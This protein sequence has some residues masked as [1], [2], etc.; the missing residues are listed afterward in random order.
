MN[1]ERTKRINGLVFAI[2]A[3]L[4]MELPNTDDKD[5]NEVLG[6][7]DGR[8]LALREMWDELM[9]LLAEKGGLMQ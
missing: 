5:I 6:E 8:L 1:D 3:T 2:N 7:Y 9:T 4:Q